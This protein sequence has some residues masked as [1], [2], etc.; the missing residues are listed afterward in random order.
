MVGLFTRRVLLSPISRSL[1]P[2]TSVRPLCYGAKQWSKAPFMLKGRNS[3]QKCYWAETV[4]NLLSKMLKPTTVPMY[5]LLYL[6]WGLGLKVEFRYV[7]TKAE[8]VRNYRVPFAH[9]PDNN[10]RS[11]KETC[12]VLRYLYCCSNAF[13]NE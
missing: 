2:M 11:K 12:E 13:S 1:P 9:T 10:K 3:G 8:T 6:C 7:R 4:G 5:S